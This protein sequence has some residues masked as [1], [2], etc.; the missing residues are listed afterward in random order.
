VIAAP[1]GVLRLDAADL[2]ATAGAGSTLAELDDALAAAGVWVAL[3]PAGPRTRTLG[4]VL[5]RGAGGPLAAFYGPPRDQVVGLTFVAGGGTSVHTG[6]H[7]VKNVAGFDLAK[8]IIGG[9]GAFGFV[10]E[11]HLRLRARP[12]ADRTRA[13]AGTLEALGA[14]TER[15]MT[16][17]AMLAS[18]EV[19]S[20]TLAAAIGGEARWMLLARAL[21]TAAGADEELDAARVVIG[22]ACDEVAI[23]P[24]VWPAWRDVVGAWPTLARVGADPADWAGAARLAAALGATAISATVPRGV[25][26]ARFEARAAEPVR[27]LRARAARRGWPTTLERA[28]TA[29]LEAVGIWGAMNEGVLRLAMRLRDAL[30]PEGTQGIPLWTD[31]KWGSGEVGKRTS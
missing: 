1:R 24:A 3:D 26:R 23:G 8:L 25:V 10:T 28:D 15:L 27:A 21:G 17:G 29:T 7:V 20:P 31:G 18:C 2:V 11:A 9:H 22:P 5:G 30:G 13:W 6:G 12:E 19:V 14:A 16:R 4:A